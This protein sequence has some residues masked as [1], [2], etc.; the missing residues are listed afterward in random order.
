[1]SSIAWHSG[2]CWTLPDKLAAGL[3][4]KLAA[5]HYRTSSL[6][7]TTG[8]A[9]CRT[10]PDKLAAG[11]YRTRSLADTTGQARL[12]HSARYATLLAVL[13]WEAGLD[14]YPLDVT[15]THRER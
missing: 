13:L 15:N 4:D 10:L 1:M 5:R 14:E 6:P 8:Q 11:H 2:G 12:P 9:R 3:P 7:D